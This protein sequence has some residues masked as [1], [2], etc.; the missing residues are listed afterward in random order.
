MT[1]TR[2]HFSVTCLSVRPVSTPGNLRA[3]ADITIGPLV[4]HSCRVIQQPGQRPWVA[5]PQTQAADGRWYPV[6]RTDDDT[7]RA[8]VRDRVLAACSPDVLRSASE[9]AVA[10]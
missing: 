5:M 2:D 1:I 7:L 10:A 3:L 8:A 9:T 4:I 6:I